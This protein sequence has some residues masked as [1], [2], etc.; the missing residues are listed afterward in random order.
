MELGGRQAK[1][2]DSRGK[3]RG[4][5][6]LEDARWTLVRHVGSIVRGYGSIVL[7]RRRR[8][9]LIRQTCLEEDV[10]LQDVASQI[11]RGAREVYLEATHR[12]GITS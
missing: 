8:E 6:G 9:K 12:F 3:V 10:T 5:L 7:G 1:G 11:R 4:C 2:L